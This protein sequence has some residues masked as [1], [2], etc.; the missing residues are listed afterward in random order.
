MKILITGARGTIGQKLIQALEGDHE[1]CLLSRS[2]VVGDARWLCARAR[3]KGVLEFHTRG[4]RR[5]LGRTLR[6][7]WIFH[8]ARKLSGDL[9]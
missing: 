2:V 4:A 7:T 8:L 3:S 6:S 5:I 9:H 1:L